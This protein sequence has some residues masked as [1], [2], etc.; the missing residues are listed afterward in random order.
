[1]SNIYE[2]TFVYSQK[3]KEEMTKIQTANGGAK[4]KLGTVIIR[5]VKKEYTE[6]LAASRSSRYPDARILITGDLR[7]ISYTPAA[8]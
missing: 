5:G 7:N 3:Q 8:E 4:P 2:R 1:M 6:M